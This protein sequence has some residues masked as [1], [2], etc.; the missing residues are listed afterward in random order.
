MESINVKVKQAYSIAHH[1]TGHDIFLLDEIN[2]VGELVPHEVLGLDKVEE[3]LIYVRFNSRSVFGYYKSNV[4]IMKNIPLEE[5]DW[6]DQINGVHKATYNELC[7][8]M[9]DLRKIKDTFPDNVEDF[10]WDVKVH[11]LMPNQFPCIPNWH[12]DN[13]PRHKGKQD[14]DKCDYTKPMY[15]WLSGTPLTEFEF[16]TTEYK[17]EPKKWFKFNQGSKHRG[18]IS[19]DFTWRGFIRATHKDLMIRSEDHNPLRRHSQVYLDSENF[20]W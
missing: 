18:T 6:R 7:E 2:A 10:Y 3:D 9:P 11:M 15:L 13:I 4:T 14:F 17:I 20:T 16:N 12:Y 8:L 5:V 19:K 1:I